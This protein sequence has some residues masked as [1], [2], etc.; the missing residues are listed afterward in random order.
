MFEI[1]SYMECLIAMLKE[2]FDVRLLFVGLQGSYLRGEATEHSD[3]DVVVILD[4][5][6]AGDLAAYR[7]IV[8]S[9]PNPEKA[10]GF[11]CGRQEMANWNPMEICS[12]LHGTKDYYGKIADYVPAYTKNDV[13]N[14]IKLSAGNM[15]H[16]LC[17]RYIHA[18]AQRNKRNL[19]GT[20]KGV[21]FI[22]Q[23][24]YYLKDGA[25]YPTKNEIIPHLDA[26]DR[27]VLEMALKLHSAGD[28][29]FEE[30]FALLLS[31][32]QMKLKG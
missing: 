1:E 14:F 25:F 27:A 10:C 20:Y 19:V 30:A 13:I 31:W 32:C 17:H 22:L 2:R 9:L 24:L 26:D 21:F 28:Y 11:I 8:E 7:A 15:Y 18:D 3:L 6:T 4:G 16:E 12:F 23:S 5:L 29:G